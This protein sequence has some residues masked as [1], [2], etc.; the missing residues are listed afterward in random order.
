M[1]KRIKGAIWEHFI[2]SP[3]IINMMVGE[4]GIPR[5]GIHRRATKSLYFC[6]ISGEVLCMPPESLL[7]YVRA[8]DRRREGTFSDDVPSL[9]MVLCLDVPSSQIEMGCRERLQESA[10]L[11]YDLNEQGEQQISKG[12]GPVNGIQGARWIET[13]RLDK[14]IP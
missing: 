10:C 11:C 7:E 6:N 8:F 3:G 13:L 1:K 5:W 2:L 14:G 9:L 4:P 12:D